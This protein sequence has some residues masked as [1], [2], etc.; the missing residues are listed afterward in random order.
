M[1]DVNKQEMEHAYSNA[2]P[3]ELHKALVEVMKAVKNIDKSMTVGEGKNSYKGVSDKD[4]KYAIGNAMAENNI[5]C[6][7]IDYKV[8]SKIDR[9]EENNGNY[10]K[11]KQS[12]FVEVVAWYKLTHSLSGE[13]QVIVGSGH[14]VDSQDKAIGKATTYSLKNALLY[15]FLVPTGAIDDTD[16][17]HS[18]N[19]EVPKKGNVLDNKLFE[20]YLN[21]CE[22]KER[23]EA[24]EKFLKDYTLTEVQ[25]KALEVLK[26]NVK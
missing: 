12:V 10:S 9:W 1:N 6:L 18:D 16:N 14:G 24:F 11:M 17:T 25:N 23:L 26:A 20:K 8:T 3:S 15:S 4:V 22:T 2:K 5:T 21:N 7:P 19:L 13:S